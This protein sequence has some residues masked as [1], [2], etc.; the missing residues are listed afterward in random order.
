MSSEYRNPYQIA[1][2][3]AGFTQEKA[4]E[5]VDVS[6]ESIRAYENGKRIPPNDVVVRMIEVYGTQFLAYQHLKCSNDVAASLLPMNVTEISLSE[7][8]LSLMDEL[9]DWPGMVGDLRTIAKDNII[10]ERERPRFDSILQKLNQ[11][12]A[13]IMSLQFA[14]QKESISAG[15]GER[16]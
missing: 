7:A 2:A 13:A 15:K 5:L 11:A 1:R 6:V 12:A 16:N 3:S 10:D 4:A 8:V 9:N 14:K